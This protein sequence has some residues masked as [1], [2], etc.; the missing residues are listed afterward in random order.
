MQGGKAAVEWVFREEYGRLIASLV[1]RFADIDIA[2]EAAGEALVA[3]LEKWPQAG[4][5]ANPGGWLTTTAGNRAIDRIR[6]ENQRD[7][8]HQAALMSYDDTPHEPTGPVEDDRLRLLFTCCHPALVPSTAPA[9]GMRASQADG[10][11]MVMTVFPIVRLL[12]ASSW[13]A[14]IASTLRPRS[15]V[16]AMGRCRPTTTSAAC[17]ARISPWLATSPPAVILL[18]TVPVCRDT[19]L[20]T[21]GPRARGPLRSVAARCPN[22]RSVSAI[23]PTLPMVPTVDN[24]RSIWSTP[25]SRS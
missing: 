20:A 5:P 4:V 22:G 16:V 14:L 9:R 6:R 3:A 2:E 25:A 7:A 24:T 12:S 21:C 19:D 10:S 18:K 8:K 23:Q 17:C 13:A 1:R 11:E 15:T